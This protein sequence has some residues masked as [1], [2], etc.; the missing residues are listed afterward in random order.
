LLILLN[1]IYTMKN[2][3]IVRL[4]III[5]LIFLC[6]SQG[7][8]SNNKNFANQT[9]AARP[10]TAPMRQAPPFKYH[11]P[12][13]EDTILMRDK[14]LNGQYKYLLTKMYHYQEPFVTSL[15][16]N[17]KDTINSDRRKLQEAETKLDVQTK[18]TGDLQSNVTEKEKSL[19]QSNARVNSVNFL[20][21]Y[22]DKSVYN[23]IMWGLV[24]IL[25]ATAAIVIFRSGSHSREAKYRINL[26]SE[27]DEEFKTYKVKANEKE[28]KLAR[29]LQT[30]RNK[31][32]E[33]MGRA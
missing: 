24:I 2:F 22:V 21:I 27:L 26:Y 19:A 33:L 17:L 18:I 5:T 25:G 8:S 30:E 31:V 16:K 32:D 4:F 11:K 6:A 7:F 15:Y 29:E 23:L 1:Q 20:G 13:K 9:P 12:T 28:K 14:S 3:F 10:A